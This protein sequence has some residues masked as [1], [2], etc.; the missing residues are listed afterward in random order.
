MIRQIIGILLCVVLLSCK[1]ETK[2][3]DSSSNEEQSVKE[4]NSFKMYEMSPM[5]VL[6]EQM[7]VD[8]QRIRDK[9]IEGLPITDSMPSLHYQLFLADMTDPSERDAFFEQQAKKYLETEE[10]FY[11]DPNT[12]TKEKFNAIV[13]SCLEC[14]AKKCG[15]PIPRI[16]KLLIP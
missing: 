13:N 2:K 16:R 11:K 1:S 12:N 14:H 4:D 7:W 9:I 15:G 5:A 6:M 3:V 10:V 8:N